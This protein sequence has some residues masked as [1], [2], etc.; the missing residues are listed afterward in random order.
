MNQRPFSPLTLEVL[1]MKAAAV[2]LFVLLTVPASAETALE[3][4]G[5]N[6][7][8]GLAP[9]GADVLTE[10]HQFDLF[11]QNADETAQQRGDEG[12]RQ[13]SSDHASAA[14]KQDKQLQALKKKAGLTVVFSEEPSVTTSGRLASLEG[15]VGAA[16]VQR[17]YEAQAAEYTS[18]LSALRRY[19]DNPDNND[20]KSF[21]AKRVP[22]FEAAQKDVL[23]DWKRAAH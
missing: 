20:I 8:L 2:L 13:F 19:L 14:Q 23:E 7:M 17:Y 1:T 9:T 11:E 4:A 16:F 22:L 18:V 21:A 3:K 5:V 12:L 6:G 10:V 15:S